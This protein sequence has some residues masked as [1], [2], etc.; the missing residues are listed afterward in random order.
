M[1]V[2]QLAYVMACPALR[3]ATYLQL[4][5]DAMAEF[6]INQS[7]A[8]YLGSI[9]HESAGLLYTVEQGSREYLKYLEGRADLGNLH[10]G[11]GYK[12][13]G[14]ALIQITGH[15]NYELVSKALGYDYVA[16]P[17]QLAQPKD[18]ARASAWW[19]VSNGCQALATTH[20]NGFI[21]VSN[22]LSV[23]REINL[24]NT[25]T[26]RIPNGWDSRLGYFK[27]ALTIYPDFMNVQ[28]GV[29]TTAPEGA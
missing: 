10:P 16:D 5:L 4:I 9:G 1:N 15:T 6:A 17:D 27:R 22:F 2:D 3:A 18:A 29:D 14:R 23:N 7:Q 13:R 26:S 8:S 11:D 19:Y 28:A 20:G 25:H 21:A 12:Y 24:G